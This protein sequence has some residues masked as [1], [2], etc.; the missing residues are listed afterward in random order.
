MGAALLAIVAGL[1]A[2]LP[3]FLMLL[4]RRAAAQAKGVFGAAKHDADLLESVL[5]PP[6]P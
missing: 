3:Q 6:A 4:E 5:R 1:I 2:A